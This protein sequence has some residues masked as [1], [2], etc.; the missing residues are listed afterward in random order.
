[1]T[2]VFGV[3]VHGDVAG[4]ESHRRNL[5]DWPT[6]MG[7]VDAG[8][9]ATLDMYIGYFQPYYNSHDALDKDTAVQEL[10]PH[11]GAFR[12]RP[13]GKPQRSPPDADSRLTLQSAAASL[14]WPGSGCWVALA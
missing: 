3:V 2:R 14:A 10:L 13:S 12:A 8:R 4:A 11:G 1:M 7:M 5:V 9:V 6:W